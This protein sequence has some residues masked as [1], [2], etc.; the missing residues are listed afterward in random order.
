MTTK[1]MV[2][3]V[4][5]VLVLG[6]LL[7]WQQSKMSAM[8]TNV[9]TNYAS[10]LYNIGESM[11]QLM[12]HI[13][14]ATLLADAELASE[15]LSGIWRMTDK[16]RYEMS[17][18]P[19]EEDSS[20]L[21]L[22]YMARIGDSAKLAEEGKIDF[23]EWTKTMGSTRE[24]LELVVSEWERTNGS[25][26]K[27]EQLLTRFYYSEL[28]EESKKGIEN[29][30][31]LVKTY[32]ESDMPVTTSESDRAKKI[33]LANLKGKDFEENQVIE[34]WK[35][36]FPELSDA[37]I[38]VT[39]SK[40][41]APYPFYHIEFSGDK[42]KGFA[43]YSV[44]GGHL[45]TFLIEKPYSETSLD[46]TELQKLAAKKMSEFGYTDVEQTSSRENHS[47]WH[48]T[49]TRKMPNQAFVYSD[50]IQLKLAKDTGDLLGI[51][52][53]E[54]IQEESLKEVTPKELDPQS[55]V[56]PETEILETNLAYL[57][58][59]Q[60]EQVL[61]YEVKVQTKSGQVYTLF[62]DAVTH[63]LIKKEHIKG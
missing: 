39:E 7:F 15:D 47:A 28:D 56:S 46:P 14:G 53:M 63:K 42:V 50:S 20:T 22:N 60:F 37:T 27:K 16:I 52:P 55:L 8:E 59:H 9:S 2:T 26:T 11:D 48:F 62:V 19:F 12:E 43:D 32:T 1:W 23:E 30:D 3:L 25:I 6:G 13:D 24:N 31:K 18:L 29:L 35:K 49:F 33:E 45:L 44:K 5:T 58:N 57:E 61:C 34:K 41:S 54:Y 36:Q 4:A 38:R 40:Q 21:W 17:T 10:R 51:Q